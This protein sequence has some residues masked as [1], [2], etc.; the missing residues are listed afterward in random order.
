MFSWWPLKFH[1]DVERFTVAHI[2]RDANI[3]C[4]AVVRIQSFVFF[5][6]QIAK[7][8]GI[9]FFAIAYHNL[10]GDTIVI[11]NSRSIFMIL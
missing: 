10:D 7:R 11:V 5:V 9:A 1:E 8:F 4:F 3:E 6:W 2:S